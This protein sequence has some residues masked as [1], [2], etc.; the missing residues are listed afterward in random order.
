[1]A[2]AK[3]AAAIGRINFNWFGNTLYRERRPRPEIPEDGLK[4]A[5]S[6]KPVWGKCAQ[7]RKAFV[8]VAQQVRMFGR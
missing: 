3:N 8:Q 4:V 1:M 2:V 5:V 7:P 6:P